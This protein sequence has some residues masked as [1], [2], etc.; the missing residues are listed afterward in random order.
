[1]NK[2]LAAD[3]DNCPLK[4]KPIARS[5]GPKNATVAFV[6]RSPGYSDA[7]VGKP[8]QGPSG[9]IL[10]FLLKENGVKREEILLTNTVLC[11]PDK[12][13][14]PPLAI[15]ACAK[16]LEQD[17]QGKRLVIAAGKEAVSSVIGRGAID[18]YRGYRIQRNGTTYVAT[19]NPALVLRDDSTFP[20]LKRDFKRAFH[21]TPEPVFPKVEVIEDANSA[22]Q[23]INHLSTSSFAAADIETRGG[24]TRR[25]TIV[26]MQ[27]AVEPGIAYVLGERGGLFTNT[28]FM[29]NHLQQWLESR[30]TNFCWHNGKFDTK[31]LRHSYGIQ[32]RV[33]E[34][35]MLLNYALDER[36]GVHAL[37]YCLMEEFGWPNYEPESV[38]KFKTTGVVTDYDELYEYAGRDAAG[39][40]QLYELLR[41]RVEIEEVGDA[42]QLLIE[43]SEALTQ[44]E[45]AGFH[46]DSVAAGDLMEEEVG[47]ELKQIKRNLRTMLDNPLYNPASTKQNSHL[48]YDVWKITHAVQSR[49][50]KERSTDEA[51]LNEILGGRF[52]TTTPQD[53]DLILKFSRELLRF[54][55]LAK[56]ASTY[57]VGMMK[58]AKEEP[59][60]KVYTNL[61]LHNTTSGRLSSRE[62]N[63]QNITRTKEGLPDIRRLFHASNGRRIVQADYS[64]AELRCIAQFSQDPRLVAI[65]SEGMDLHNI[66]AARFFGADYTKEQRSVSKNMNFGM[67]YRQSAS[68]FQEKHGIPEAQAQ[69]YIDWAKDEFSTVWTWEVGIEKE[70]HGQGHLRSPFGRKRRFHLITPENKNAVYREGINFYPQSTA[71]DLTLRSCIILLKEIDH[72]RADVILTVHDSIIADVEA[73][74]ED[75]YSEIC[76]QIMEARAKEDINWDIPLVVDIKSGMTWGDC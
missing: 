22:K 70:I 69:K 37:D 56:L 12:G 76:Q 66:T 2:H 38:K 8:F 59:D 48:Y 4:S 72:K 33:D 11:A 57:I 25:A 21:P 34:D 15:K 36:G 23:L 64:Q 55:S 30:S 6:S 35:T 63:L 71:S 20:N 47:P 10:D 28:D 49:P 1:M 13:K 31:V 45:L 46:Y 7:M 60:G 32:T 43:G 75:D 52:K 26:S 51:A 27:F 18:R 73:E 74:Y 19:N 14:V 17:L 24:L 42:Y 44:I 67:F 9:D 41:P 54:R 39:T 16:R 68:T 40:F 50:D 58:Q 62:P 3:C 65:Y 61:W 53:S 29:V 5:L